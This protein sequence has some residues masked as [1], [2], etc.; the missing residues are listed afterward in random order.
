MQHGCGEHRSH[1]SPVSLSG[2]VAS[3]VMGAA[4]RALGKP[5]GFKSQAVFLQAC[6][7]L[8]GHLCSAHGDGGGPQLPAEPSRHACPWAE[9]RSEYSTWQFARGTGVGDD[10]GPSNPSRSELWPIDRALPWDWSFPTHL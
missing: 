10:L 6:L 5:W 9:Q 7:P 1:D 3:W 4:L 8:W 2:W